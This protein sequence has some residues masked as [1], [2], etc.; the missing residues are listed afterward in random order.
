MALSISYFGGTDVN[1]MQCYGECVSRADVTLTGS[2]ASMGT[3][4]TNAAI[5][6]VTA[7]EA[8]TVS[9]NGTAASATNGVSLAAN[10]VIDMAVI[11]GQ[12][13]LAKTG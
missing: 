10:A 3:P 2:S 9:N 11:R 7:G 8:C 6:R 12:A 4:P 1:T 13:L 5:A